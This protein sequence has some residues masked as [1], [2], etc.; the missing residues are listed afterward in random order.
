M[1]FIKFVKFTWRHQI[2]QIRPVTLHLT[3]HQIRQIRRNI[4]LVLTQGLFNQPQS[5]LT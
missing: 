1:I 2:R 4:Y 5:H 3:L